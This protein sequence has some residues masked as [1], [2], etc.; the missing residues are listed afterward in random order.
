M[1]SAIL[2]ANTAPLLQNFINANTYT[3]VNNTVVHNDT[4]STNGTNFVATEND[5]IMHLIDQMGAILLY[6][7]VPNQGW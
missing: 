4:N 7:S 1:L 5:E 6:N 3:V 2:T